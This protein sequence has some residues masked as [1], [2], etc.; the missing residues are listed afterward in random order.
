MSDRREQSRSTGIV[1][2]PG[3]EQHETGRHPENAERIDAVVE[4]LRSGPD[5]DR[6]RILEARRAGEDDIARAHTRAHMDMVNDFSVAGPT[7]IDGDT[8]V[9][10]GTYEVAMRASGAAILAVEEVSGRGAS[11]PDGCPDSLFAL[12]RPPGHH[13]T[14][15][16]A[17]GFCMFNHAAVA[18]RYAQDVLGIERVAILDWDVHHGNGTQ[19][20]FE[21][22][23]SV[24]FTSL[25][26][27]PL[28]PG[29]GWFEEVGSGEGRGFTVNLPIPPGSGD[30]E[31]VEALERVALPVMAEFDPGLV[32][33]SAGQDGHVADP[34]S[35][36]A[37]TV[38]GYHDLAL[39]T[40][41]FAA[42]RGIGLVAVHEGGYNPETLPA[43]DHAILA[44]FA[45]S[46][47]VPSEPSV[48]GAVPEPGGADDPGWAERLGHIEQCLRP[49]WPGAIRS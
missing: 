35:N 25:H 38:T 32:I 12:I 6:L 7:W 47:A 48:R 24:L 2:L 16:R 36:Q 31:H 22:D 23:R 20:I 28:Y 29:S 27:W 45:N 19:D 4:H 5:R 13:A 39:K 33:V 44:G 43:L 21:A 46:P 3:H 17:M 37:L 9:S 26:Q 15:D 1:V 40:A 49:F 41:G 14:A 18:A 30:A 11:G 42:D 8:V 10:P 34:L